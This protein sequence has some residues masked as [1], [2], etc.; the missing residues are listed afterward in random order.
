MEAS[1]GIEPVYTDLQSAASPLRQLAS[2]GAYGVH[3]GGMQGVSAGPWIL[4]GRPPFGCGGRG[5]VAQN[6]P[7][8]K[9]HGWDANGRFQKTKNDDGGHAGS[10]VRRD[11][12]S[13]Y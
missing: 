6:G 7:S 2:R 1:T 3:A 12:V 13:D 11:Q 4:A 9:I 5:A 8:L 10:S